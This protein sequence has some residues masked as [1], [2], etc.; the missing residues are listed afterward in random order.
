MGTYVRVSFNELFPVSVELTTGNCANC[1]RVMGT[2]MP[3]ND[4]WKKLNQNALIAGYDK[5]ENTW[6]F[7]YGFQR[8]LLNKFVIT[9][10]NK[11]EAK[12]NE[13]KMISFGLKFIHLNRDMKFDKVFN[14]V[15]RANL[16]YGIRFKWFY[17]FGGIALNYFFQDA[18]EPRE[19]YSVRSVR[20]SSRRLFGL[21]TSCWPGYTVGLHFR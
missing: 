4:D 7:G 10:K 2:N 9:P 12:M 3:Y 8:V 15:S 21:N 18:D 13:S 11:F 5:I 17:I 19:V 6:G 16:E 14:L 1:S 20:I